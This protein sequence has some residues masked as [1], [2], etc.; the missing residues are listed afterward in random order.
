MLERGKIYWFDMNP[1]KG[2]EPGKVRPCL[3]YQID[4]YN[5]TNPDAYTVIP[6]T[7]QEESKYMEKQLEIAKENGDLELV[8]NIEYQMSGRFR[9]LIERGLGNLTYNSS[10]MITRITTLSKDRLDKALAD[11]KTHR[12]IPKHVMLE[13]DK[14]VA[15]FLGFPLQN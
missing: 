15:Y 2:P 12:A 4:V 6:L 13:I 9:H 3:V 7:T 14:K 10:A 1:N 8:K 11:K 5:K